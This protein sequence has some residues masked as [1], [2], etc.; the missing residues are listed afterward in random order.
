M[1]RKT[2][3]ERKGKG[4]D[5]VSGEESTNGRERE[6]RGCERERGRET[7]SAGTVAPHI[8]PPSDNA[9]YRW[10]SQE[11]EEQAEEKATMEE[12]AKEKDQAEVE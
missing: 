2:Q 5:T 3:R 4:S 7:A 9:P 11:E 12:K 1:K 6:R 8:D 10:E